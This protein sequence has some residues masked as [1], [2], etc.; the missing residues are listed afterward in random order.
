MK[1]IKIASI[2][3][4]IVSLLVFG[5]FTIYR[6]TTSDHEAPVI[7]CDSEELVL[8][9][10]T[11]EKE[12]LADVKAQDNKDGDVT[13]A[14]VIEEMTAFTE[15]NTRMITYAVIDEA[16]NVGRLE[17]KLVYTD[18]EKPKFEFTQSMR[19]P[20]GKTIN[21]LEGVSAS[22]PLDGDLTDSIKY[23]LESTIDLTKTGVHQVEYRVMDS[24]GNIVYL[25]IEIEIYNV[26]EERITVTLSDYLVYVSV[27]GKFDPKTYYQGAS[28][29]G[30]LQIQSGVNVK[31]EGIYYVDYTVKGTVNSGKSRLIVVVT[32]S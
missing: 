4:F 23:S 12:L 19:F 20:T 15:E 26:S 27:N 9:V 17:R 11:S 21:L 13:D 2:V 29:E 7:T 24:A 10:S 25:P 6:K 31:E 16:G 5:V 8:S 3:L 14:V 32:G 30:E 28:E 18:Y 1:K 22:S